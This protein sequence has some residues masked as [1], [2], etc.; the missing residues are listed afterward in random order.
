MRLVFLGLSITSSWGNGHA[1]N[2]R[3]LCS[4]LRERGHDVLFLERDKPWYASGRDFHPDWVRLYDSVE[5]LCAWEEEVR[6]AD[7]VVVGSFVP[8]GIA[9]A[10][11]AL[12]V[13]RGPV[14]FWDIDTP[15]T[16]AAL[17]RGECEY[18]TPALV[19]RFDLY[20]SFTGGPLLDQLGARRPHAFWCMV[21]AGGYAPLPGEP[22]WHLGYLGTYAGDRQPAL[23]ELLLRPARRC[24]GWRFAVA[25]PMY[26]DSVEWPENV[27]RIENVP[28]RRHPAFYSAQRFTLNLT[29]A[30]MIRAGWSPSVRL[31]EAAACA[32]PIISDWWEGLDTFFEPDR[33]LLVAD[34]ADDVLRFLTEVPE[35]ERRRIGGRARVRVLREH[36]AVRRAAA[37]ERLVHELERAT[38]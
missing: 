4:A 3:A 25:G 2:Y 30:D 9:V 31:F 8:D 23:E 17:R 16:A 24:R 29:R 10:E 6:E 36:T 20:L 12:E 22:R 7:L 19:P 14:A 18:L 37:L 33:E 13:A 5:D 35:D 15:V 38:A 34:D 1:T 28:P 21:D 27:D 32:V 11:W 26:P